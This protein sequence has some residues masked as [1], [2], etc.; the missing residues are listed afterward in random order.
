MPLPRT[1]SPSASYPRHLLAPIVR[2]ILIISLMNLSWANAALPTDMKKLLDEK[3]GGTLTVDLVVGQAVLKADQFRAIVAEEFAADAPRLESRALIEP[4]LRIGA[5]VSDDEREPI[6]VFSPARTKQS[7]GY[8]SLSS[9]FVTGTQASFDI[10]HGSTNI[11]FSPLTAVPPLGTNETRYLLSVRQNLLNNIFGTGT[12]GALDAGRLTAESRKLQAMQDQ[13]DWIIQLIEAYYGAWLAQTKVFAARDNTARRTRLLE[14]TQL[15]LRRGTA[16]EPDLLQVKAAVIN[17]KVQ[18]D[19]AKQS[20]ADQWRAL[21]ITLKMPEAWLDVDASQI[22]MKLDSP[23][24]RAARLCAK[25]RDDKK[26]SRAEEQARMLF[27][28]SQAAEHRAAWAFKPE[29]NLVGALGANAVDPAAGATFGET[30]SRDHPYWSVGVEVSMPL[31][32]AAERAAYMTATLNR[33]RAEALYSVTTDTQRMLW[34]NRCTDLARAKSAA[35]HLASGFQSQK[36]R[37][38]LEEERF[39]IGRAGMLAVIQ[40]GDDATDAEVRWRQA[41]VDSRLS[42]WRVVR[43]ADGVGEYV[44]GLA[45]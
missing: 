12:R 38:G 33:V 24:D 7:R 28:A 30:F 15:K 42:A 5:D 18:E 8:L 40:A 1:I 43:L 32:F 45:Q 26:S 11:R 14:T 22:P 34:H 25:W 27:E 9:Q 21:V 2:T 29:L 17:A 10:S 35:E 37:A 6:V 39:R 20:L 23:L 36:R 44:K 19:G 31:G 3:A 13:E 16:E 4:K 41:E